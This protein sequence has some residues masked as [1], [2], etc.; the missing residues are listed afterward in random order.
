MV[1]GVAGRTAE[2]EEIYGTR[3]G[4]FFRIAVAI[5]R[6]EQLAKEAVH[7]AGR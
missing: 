5:V 7:D 3:Y 6:D 4:T 2:I 1:S